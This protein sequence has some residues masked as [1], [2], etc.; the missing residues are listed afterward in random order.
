MRG[1]KW[2]LLTSALI[3]SPM[4]SSC[5]LHRKSDNVQVRQVDGRCIENQLNNCFQRVVIG[6]T[7]S[8]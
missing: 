5:Q 2:M 4:T 1:E 7:K 3:L 8:S 6:G